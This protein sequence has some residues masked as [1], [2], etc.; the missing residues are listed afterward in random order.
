MFINRL[1]TGVQT[2]RSG[3]ENVH[4]FKKSET[5]TF[6]FQI[7]TSSKTAGSRYSGRLQETRKTGGLQREIRIG[8]AKFFQER[9]PYFGPEPIIKIGFA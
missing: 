2:Q 4:H 6:H 7:D 8:Q 3:I 1:L 9:K 5:G